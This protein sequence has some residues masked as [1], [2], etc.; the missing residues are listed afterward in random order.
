MNK[1]YAVGQK[2]ATLLTLQEKGFN[3]PAFF[4]IGTTYMEQCLQPIKAELEQLLQNEAVTTEQINT[5]FERVVCSV[6]LKNYL[7]GQELMKAKADY[8]VRSS[9][10]LEDSQQHSFAGQFDT[11]LHVTRADI[12]KAIIQCWRSAFSSNILSYMQKSALQL[13]DLLMGVIVQKMQIGDGSGVLFSQNPQGIQNEMVIVYGNAT[14][15]MVVE[16]RVA[17]DTYHIN[18]TDRQHYIEKSDSVPTLS[19]TQITALVDLGE[20]LEQ[21]FNY[22]IDAEYVLQ[23]DVVF[24]LQTRPITTMPHQALTIL[25]NSNITESYPGISLPLTQSFVTFIYGAIF[26]G[27]AKRCIPD[28]RMIDAQKDVLDNMVCALNGSMYYQISNWYTLLKYLP[29][30]KKIIPIW[31]EMLGV[32]TKAVTTTTIKISV[33]QKIWST[34]SIVKQTFG[35]PKKM[36]IL[37]RTFNTT[38]SYFD[39]QIAVAKTSTSL[40]Q[41]YRVLQ[42]QVLQKWDITLLNDLYAFIFTGIL[43][44]MLGN[45]ELANAHISNIAQIESMKPVIEMQKLAIQLQASPALVKSVQ[46][47]IETAD[48]YYI[49]VA[50]SFYADCLRFIKTY[51]DRSVEEL[52]LETTTFRTN[53]L[54]LLQTLLQ[55]KD[56]NITMNEAHIPPIK[57][58][59]IK[60][61]SKRAQ[62]GIMHREASRLNRTR[63]FGMVR[64]I[65][66]AIAQNFVTDGYI[67]EVADIFYLTET[68]IE[69][70]IKDTK[71]SKLQSLVTKR[72]AEI[73]AFRQY[74][75][76]SR[77]VFYGKPF[78]RPLKN[79]AQLNHEES[80]TIFYG[81]PSSNGQVEAEVI[82]VENPQTLQNVQGKIIVAK[83]TDPGWVFL[84]LQAKGIIAENGSILSHTAIISRE[85]NIPA[86]VGV[87]GIM[88]T[89]KTGDR[90]ILD[91]T[92]GVVEIC[93][94][95]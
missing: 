72:K 10:I 84:L 89:L 90:V 11:I 94:M 71:K 82:V 35:I 17:T 68:E 42:Q 4:V 85:L 81:I 15:D 62:I 59:F 69:Q 61:V 75:I 66:L 63:I 88:N 91:G 12:E 79:I 18:R 65:Y 23:G 9:A 31:Q 29:F 58:P 34:F 73:D 3:V 19:R 76:F 47:A 49:Q 80:Q 26:T 7:A 50:P 38:L 13:S 74:P 8:S 16:D 37:A 55:L 6:E 33:W 5:L 32:E 48:F 51:G 44:K 60:W 30:S 25:D 64:T 77:V 36:T 21:L 92:K 28:K 1:N 46:T 45:T 20:R 95:K 24:L 83:M 22:P 54:L 41:L 27:L 78:N 52:K 53:P 87:K 67:N 86:V 70:A 2:A 93:Q 56:Q 43:K 40:L 39:E 57:N 14:G